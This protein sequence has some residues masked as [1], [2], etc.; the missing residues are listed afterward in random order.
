MTCST[1]RYAVVLCA[2]AVSALTASN[3][4]AAG[5][6]DTFPFKAFEAA[7]YLIVA[8]ERVG[9]NTDVAT[10]NFELGANKAP[11]PA[12]TDFVNNNGGPSLQ[13][14]VPD[15]PGSGIV[16][17]FQGIGGGGNIAVTDDEGEFEL[18]DVGVYGDPDIGIRVAAPDDSYNKSSNSFFNDSEHFPN[19]FDVNTQ[20]GV[21]VNPNDANQNTRIDP[22]GS[23]HPSNNVGVTYGY[24][25][26]TLLSELDNARSVINGLATTTTLDVSGNGG[27]ISNDTTFNASAGLNVV[28]IDTGDNDFLIENANFIVDGPEDS[29]VIFRLPGK[30]NM[31]ISNGNI[32]LGD[33]GIGEHN[34][35]FYTDQEEDDTHFDFSN[36]ILNH[37]AFWSLSDAGGSI[38]ISNAQGCTQL[39]ADIVDLDNVRFGRCAH[40]PE[41]GSLALLG[42]GGL[43]LL[44]RR[45]R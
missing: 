21:D 43:V 42:L 18:Q 4:S 41:P 39:I 19:T 12:N 24:D 16:P 34:V 25:H 9:G 26:T 37:V 10:N 36:A 17:V 6:P 27:K 22:S 29:V 5:F 32:L 20:T 3:A 28:D 13:G 38:G 1:L 7:Q 14:N 15:L 33:G 2:A 11:V 30:D 44:R 45:T 31:K 35:L 40:A 23:G 8:R